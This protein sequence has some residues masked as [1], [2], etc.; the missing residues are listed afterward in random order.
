MF[1]PILAAF[2]IEWNVDPLLLMLPATLSASMAFTMPVATPP[3]MPSFLALVNSK[4]PT[5]QNRLYHQHFW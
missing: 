4:S 3:Q 2:A 5:W 1:L